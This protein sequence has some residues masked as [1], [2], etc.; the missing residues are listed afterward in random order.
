[1]ESITEDCYQRTVAVGESRGVVEIR[2]DAETNALRV[3]IEGIAYHRLGEVVERARRVFDLGADPLSIAEQLTKNPSI[4]VLVRKHPGIRV[5]GA[6]EPFE[7]AVRAVL[8]EQVCLETANSLAG[9][10][11]REFGDPVT[12]WD[13]FDLT[14]VFPCAQALSIAHLSSVGVGSAAARTIQLLAEAVATRRITLEIGANLDEAIAGLRSVPGIGESTA[15]YIAMRA[16]GE[17]DAF[18]AAELGLQ[19]ALPSTADPS[20]KI[21]SW[22]PWRAYAAMYLWANLKRVLRH[23]ALVNR[24]G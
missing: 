17:P 21:Q 4:A 16:L 23:R 15:S 8:G 13:E 6:W 10:L 12:R 9:Q 19:D 11:A 22:R 7:V 3:R 2:H 20:E 24:C 14:H 1:M 5:P 18:P